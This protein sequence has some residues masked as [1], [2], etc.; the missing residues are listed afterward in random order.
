MRKKLAVVAALVLSGFG[1][2]VPTPATAAAKPSGR[3][4]ALA[5]CITLATQQ[6]AAQWVCTADGLTV[7]ALT[8]SGQF[9]STFTPVTPAP[10]AAAVQDFGTLADDYDTW[11]ETGSV[12]R[13]TLSDYL[14][15]TKGNA[16]YGNTSGVIGTY[17]VILRTN[18]NGRQGQWRVSLIWD[19]GPTLSFS[20][21][22]V[23]C[24]EDQVGPDA[25]C[26]QHPVGGAVVG[27]STKRWDSSIV[28]GNRLVDANDYFAT[29]N[30]T[31]TPSGYPAY[32]A[33]EL[34]SQS[35]NCPSG[36]RNCVFP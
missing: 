5:P 18:L 36:D 35:F 2:A 8:P 27:P 1:L 23:N 11:C 17:D 31:F 32:T 16:A 13:R 3:L 12:C 15:E 22:R 34:R 29:V 4:A 21:T 9:T 30:T 7:T 14:A 10:T 26:G 24:R 25:D 19:S 20:N 28:Y 6:H 33:A